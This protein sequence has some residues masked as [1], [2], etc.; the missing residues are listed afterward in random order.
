MTTVTAFTAEKSLEIAQLGQFT[1]MEVSGDSYAQGV[2]SLDAVHGYSSI[3]AGLLK[4][5]MINH[6]IGGAVC[7][8]PK[9]ALGASG[10]G[11]FANVLQD[12]TSLNNPAK[13]PYMSPGGLAS[14]HYS[15]NDL[16]DNGHAAAIPRLISALRL[17]IGRYRSG[18]QFEVTH[19]A[20]GAASNLTFA[21]SQNNG[22]GR[23]WD[24]TLGSPATLT[25]TVPADL[26]A[27][28]IAGMYGVVAPN[29]TGTI[30][31][32]KNGVAQPAWSITLD[33]IS[34]TLAAVNGWYARF[35]GAAPGDVIVATLTYAGSGAFVAVNGAMVES[36]HPRVVLVQGCPYPPI[37]PTA[38]GWPDTATMHA[39][40]DSANTA[41][42][43]LCNEFTD[44]RVI[45]YDVKSVLGSVAFGTAGSK[46]GSDNLH[47]TPSAH[48]ELA[49]AA[50][51]ALAPINLTVI[52][53]SKLIRYPPRGTRSWQTIRDSVSG[54][55]IPALTA[56]GT[57][58]LLAS[59]T[60]NALTGGNGSYG[61]FY[62][63]PADYGG[64]M[65]LR[66]K[67]SVIT[68][69]VAQA[70]TFT[71]ELKQ[72]LTWGGASGA[73]P[74]IATLSAVI[75]NAAIAAPVAGGPSIVT[76]T[77][78]ILLRAGW[79]VLDLTLSAA[80]AANGQLFAGV[81]LEA[82]PA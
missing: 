52:E 17:V 48:A 76:G 56:A 28:A 25:F 59:G 57:Y 72:V 4:V 10:D 46:Y 41:M 49:V 74:A 81:K 21:A 63:D 11:G 44:G 53:R 61:V 14:L 45:F 78:Q 33:P 2:G 75:A 12:V 16:W 73:N 67:G 31:F 82:Q 54:A 15:F 29:T 55:L 68:N 8:W 22:D 40:I 5:P 37:D 13:A 6:A 35:I 69:A 80:V 64:A 7:A 51:E 9:S 77:P 50:F 60:A 62:L 39:D 42:Q 36:D 27:G 24:Q 26:P 19:S 23:L 47:P 79:Y 58:A 65:R 18:G 38:Y 32:T 30:T 43:N 66:V 70:A 71:F 34:N 20:F 1:D 3:L